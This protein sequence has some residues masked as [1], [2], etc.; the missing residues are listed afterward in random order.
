MIDGNE[1]RSSFC[2]NGSMTRGIGLG[3]RKRSD[4][5]EGW[6][7]TLPSASTAGQITNIFQEQN[8]LMAARNWRASKRK[9]RIFQIHIQV[10]ILRETKDLSPNHLPPLGEMLRLQLSMTKEKW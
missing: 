8:F 10:V 6:R 5:S 1:G 9:K 4:E 3:E 2:R 7:R